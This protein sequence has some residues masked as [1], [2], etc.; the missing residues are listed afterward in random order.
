[1]VPCAVAIVDMAKVGMPDAF[2]LLKR[3]DYDR[4]FGGWCLPGGK[5]EP[6]ETPE[7]A[8]IRETLEETGYEI[9]IVRLIFERDCIVGSRE[10]RV[11]AFL[12]RCVGGERIEFPN[13]EHEDFRI[14]YPGCN[15]LEPDSVT[16]QVI[17][18]HK[19]GEQ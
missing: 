8:V 10:F 17:A 16:A 5:L 19:K 3:Y 7:Q 12:A 2:P 1:M 6:G 13:R 15:C 14:V 11:H 18:E 9:E 4:T